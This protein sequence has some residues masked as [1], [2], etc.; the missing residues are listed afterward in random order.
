MTRS[1]LVQAL[2]ANGT[3]M[4][5][6]LRAAPPEAFAQGRYENGWNARQILAHVASMEWTYRNLIEIARKARDEPEP[7]STA[8]DSPPTREM[9][10]GNDAYNARQVEKRASA[11]I[12][13][14]LEEFARN[15]AQ[16]IAA[17]EATDE[18]LLE[19]PI[20]SGGGHTGSLE[21][22]LRTVAIDHVSSHVRDITGG[23]AG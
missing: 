19:V 9:R 16:T 14:L 20:R 11:T 15:R 17:V 18:A 8:G 6:A 13:E 1:E 21:V 3:E 5:A 23:Q 7:G 10:G 2:R 22:V 4:L 12:H